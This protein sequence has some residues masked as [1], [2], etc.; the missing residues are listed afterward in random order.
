MGGTHGLR[1]A[2]GQRDPGCSG[3]APPPPKS[4]RLRERRGAGRARVSGAGTRCPGC[5]AWLPSC[6]FL[7]WSRSGGGDG[8]GEARGADGNWRRVRGAERRAVPTLRSLLLAPPM[9]LPGACP[10]GAAVQ[11]ARAS[12]TQS[13]RRQPRKLKWPLFPVF[14]VSYLAIF[15]WEG[16]PLRSKGSAVRDRGPRLL[17]AGKHGGNVW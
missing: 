6:L 17:L 16:A 5:P 9:S 14:W 3:L 7:S 15:R 10:P 8:G 4:R 12:R 13:P 2:R 1:P 11:S